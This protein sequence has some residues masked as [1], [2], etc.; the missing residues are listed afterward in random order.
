MV[1][2]HIKEEKVLR[3]KEIKIDIPEVYRNK[4]Q[5]RRHRD[6]AKP[7]L[8]LQLIIEIL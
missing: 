6:T 4:E 5:V 1:R 2:P 3:G 7:H 8:R